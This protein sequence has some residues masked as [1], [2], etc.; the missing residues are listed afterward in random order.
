M[1]QDSPNGDTHR[2]GMHDY[3]M[4]DVRAAG[5][6]RAV[7]DGLLVGGIVVPARGRRGE[8]RFTFEDVVAFRAAQSLRDARIPTRQ[9]VRALR[10]LRERPADVSGLRLSA[11]GGKLAFRD[12]DHQWHVDTGQLL[13]DFDPNAPGATVLDFPGQPP[14]RQTRGEATGHDW[15]DIAVRLEPTDPEAA[16]DAYLRAIHAIPDWPDAYLHLGCMLTD[17]GRH[18]DAIALYQQGLD[19]LPQEPLLHFNLAIALE[20]AGEP[21]AALAHYAH[22]IALAPTFADAHFNAAR[23]HELLGDAR[24]AIRHYSQYRRLHRV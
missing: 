5:V 15:F 17:A 14:T 18:A 21:R 16:E 9:I 23:L 24:S 20:D 7:V 19:H 1:P 22:A 11:V 8:L 10:R 13:L 12:Q 4:H 3:G 2:S 6:S